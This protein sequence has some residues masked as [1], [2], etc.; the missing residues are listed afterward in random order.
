MPALSLPLLLSIAVGP[1]RAD[2]PLVGDGGLRALDP[3][4]PPGLGLSAADCAACHERAAAQ[5]SR[6]RHAVAGTNPLFWEAWTRLP[7][8]WCVNCHA[9]LRSGQ[10][11]TLGGA[12]RPGAL[13]TPAAPA[14]AWREGVTCAACH[15]RDGAVLTADPPSEAAEAA[16]PT[17]HEPALG[18]VAA[19]QG[20]HDFPFQRHDAP[21]GEL[22]LSTSPAQATVAEWATSTAAA[23]GRPCQDCHMQDAGHR[24]PGAHDPELVRSALRVEVG[25]GGAFRVTAPGAAHRVPTGDPFRRLLLQ[26]CADRGCGQVVDQLALRRVFARDE[27]TWVEVADRTVPPQTPSSPARRDLALS[28]EGATWWRLRYQL[29]D[30]RHEALLPPDQAGYTVHDG[31]LP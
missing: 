1:S 9:P 22:W 28:V 21:R 6:S 29:S 24:F 27:Q 12:V 4:G 31:P 15:V 18:T 30:V 10:Q 8:G 2:G 5:W 7:L 13:V 20:C 25:P 14:G 11:A 23:E 3:V 17:R 26:T 16:H 19:C